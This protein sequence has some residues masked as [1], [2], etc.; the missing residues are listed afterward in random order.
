MTLKACLAALGMLVFHPLLAADSPGKAAES[1][2]LGFAALDIDGQEQALARYKGKVLLIVNVASKCG[3]TPQYQGL[4]A[5]YESHKDQ[6]LVVLGFPSNDFLWQEPGS[7]S[8]IK[9]FCSS[10]F[11]VTF[12]MFGKISVKGKGMHPLYKY[13]TEQSPLPG[14]ISW[15]FNKFLCDRQGHVVARFGSKVKPD[16][17]ELLEALGKALT[18]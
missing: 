6:G 5:L 9:E 13:L 11:H 1:G 4:Q 12:P 15:N 3:F 8:Q 16:S 18:Q 17:P 2:V 7:N 14:A 10:K